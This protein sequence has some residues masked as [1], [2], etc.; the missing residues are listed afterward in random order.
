MK[1]IVIAIWIFA[2]L[3]VGA[4]A[5]S[6]QSALIPV[7]VPVGP[8]TLPGSALS[9]VSPDGLSGT[10]AASGV[11]DNACSSTISTIGF[12]SIQVSVTGTFVASAGLYGSWDNGAHWS[13][14]LQIQYLDSGQCT[15]SGLGAVGSFILY[16]PPPLLKLSLTAYTSGNYAATYSLRSNTGASP[17]TCGNVNSPGFNIPT[18]SSLASYGAPHYIAPSLTNF[19]QVKTSGNGNIYNWGCDS[20]TGGAAGHC[21]VIDSAAGS[22]PTTGSTITPL[23]IC[24]FSAT[25]TSC[26]KL[27][28]G[29]G[30]HANNGIEILVTSN[31]SPYIFTSGTL[32]GAPWADFH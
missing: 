2:A 17:S 26:Q 21:V 23:D 31:A 16:N 3:C 30:V 27:H 28:Q 19:G 32:T 25:Q 10:C 9:G 15:L 5:Q 7:G 24:D 1:R 4:L 6:S 8:G 13:A 29:L 12:N 22:A 14:E 18:T 20:I 11:I